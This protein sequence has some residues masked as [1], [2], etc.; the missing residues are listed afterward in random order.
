MNLK[1][2]LLTKEQFPLTKGVL[3]TFAFESDGDLNAGFDHLCILAAYQ[4]LNN[5]S[6][7]SFCG[8]QTYAP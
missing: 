6:S 7:L 2:K 3:V 4:Q 1:L 5:P 8:R